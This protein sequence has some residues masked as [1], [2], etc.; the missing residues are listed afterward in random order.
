[1]PVSSAHLNTHIGGRLG[2]KIFGCGWLLALALELFLQAVAA[3]NAKVFS[4]SI[5]SKFLVFTVISCI[6]F[7]NM[8]FQPTSF[9]FSR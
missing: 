2:K 5:R 7:Q 9:R 4:F 8:N 6:C 1:M 3:S